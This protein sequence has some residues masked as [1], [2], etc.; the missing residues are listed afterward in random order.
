M[1]G[2]VTKLSDIHSVFSLALAYNEGK[3]AKGDLS[4]PAP[5]SLAGFGRP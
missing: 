4:D 1:S 5:R 2:F 3:K